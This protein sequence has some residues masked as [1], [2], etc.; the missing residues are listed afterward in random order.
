M[1]LKCYYDWQLGAIQIDLT[2]LTLRISED[3]AKQ[4]MTSPLFTG[5]SMIGLLG[6]GNVFYVSPT[7]YEILILLM[8]NTY[9][10]RRCFKQILKE[11]KSRGRFWGC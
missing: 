5:I 8:G 10:G 3:S 4:L 2:P 11:G 6:E 1:S 7:H 9:L